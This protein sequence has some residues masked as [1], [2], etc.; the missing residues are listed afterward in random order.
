MPETEQCPIGVELRCRMET[1]EKAAEEIKES[2]KQLTNHYSS[3]PQWVVVFIITFLTSAL[4][5]AITYI[6]MAR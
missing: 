5:A 3:R 2:V 1:V 6:K 4:F